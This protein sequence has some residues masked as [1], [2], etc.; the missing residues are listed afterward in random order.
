MSTKNDMLAGVMSMLVSVVG[1]ELKNIKP[2][3][4]VSVFVKE[5]IRTLF[6]FPNS[7]TTEDY[8]FLTDLFDKIYILSANYNPQ[9]TLDRFNKFVQAYVEFVKENERNPDKDE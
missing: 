2:E 1:K 8:M 4:N 7:N 6:E 3:N 5:N 9:Q